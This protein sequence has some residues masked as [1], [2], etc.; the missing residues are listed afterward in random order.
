M[1]KQ[2]VITA[3]VLA[4]LMIIG[5]FFLPLKQFAIFIAAIATLGA[6]EW[7]NIAGYERRWGR[8]AYAL[9]VFVCLYA[10]ARLL[11]I[12]PDL[13]V[14]YLAVGALWWTVAFAL[15]RRYPGG[16]SWWTS[17]PIRGAL[18]LCVLVPMW[19]GFMHL[20]VQPH[21]SLL[22]VFVMLIVWGADTGAYFSGKRWG[23]SKLAPNVSPGKSWA[24]FWG[25]LA[26]S[27]MVAILFG[28]GLDYWLRPMS[29]DDYWQL[30]LIAVITTV[31][32]VLGD[33][34]ESMMKR[35][36]GIKDSSSLLPG[37][38]GV[39]DRIDSMAAAVPVFALCLHVLDWG[40][41]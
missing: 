26:T 17:R 24:G 10:S 18:G 2:R 23:N 4:P 21:S 37:H 5:I 15:V 13:L 39:L 40:F 7:A 16:T 31:V 1:F 11:R 12:H 35:H 19:V 22:I 28:L 29:Q 30:M 14:Y 38:G 27:A 9:M 25:G 20:K 6:W 41:A 34:V 33:L 36:R 8:V 32:S 3:M